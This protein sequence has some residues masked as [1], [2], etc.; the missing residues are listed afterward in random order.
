MKGFRHINYR[1]RQWDI[2]EQPWDKDPGF[3]MSEVEY[4]RSGKDAENIAMAIAI[5]A[6]EK[7][8]HPIFRIPLDTIWTGEGMDQRT[9]VLSSISRH[10]I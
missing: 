7:Y 5:E 3:P 2:V 4:L 1:G 10:V 6:I 9:S 8:S